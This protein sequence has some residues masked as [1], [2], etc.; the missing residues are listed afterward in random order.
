MSDTLSGPAIR[1]EVGRDPRARTRTTLSFETVKM[2]S[3]VSSNRESTDSTDWSRTSSGNRSKVSNGPVERKSLAR[4]Q[5][6]Q[7]DDLRLPGGHLGDTHPVRWRYQPVPETPSAPIAA[8]S[9]RIHESEI[10]PRQ[11]GFLMLPANRTRRV[12]RSST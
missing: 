2:K 11:R 1:A 7:R 3:P 4:K 5:A 6:H 10:S 8:A 9:T 12:A